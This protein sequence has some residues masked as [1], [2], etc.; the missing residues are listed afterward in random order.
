LVSLFSKA[1][2]ITKTRFPYLVVVA[3]STVNAF[4][5]LFAFSIIFLL[6]LAITGRFPSPTGLI[7]YLTYLVHLWLIVLGFSLGLGTLY[8]RYRDLN[9]FWDAISH[10]GFFLAP[11]MFPLAL[12]PAN[13][14]PYLFLWPP[15]PV[16]V[17]TREVL[18]AGTIPSISGHLY[19]VC[20]SLSSLAI[21]W[22][23]FRRFVRSAVEE[24]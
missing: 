22:L 17:Y 14:Q 10:A 2:L 1:N 21:G 24:L 12:L 5:T 23:I 13:V 6:F 4:I 3:T 15:T 8:L 18:V 7:L 11:I 20:I 9:H 19:L 16:I